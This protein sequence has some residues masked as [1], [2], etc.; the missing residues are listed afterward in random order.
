MQM[1]ECRK[2]DCGALKVIAVCLATGSSVVNRRREAAGSCFCETESESLDFNEAILS[3]LLE[4]DCIII[5]SRV[6]RAYFYFVT[7]FVIFIV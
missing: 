5:S 1:R 2:L 6:W 7:F 4:M 3:K